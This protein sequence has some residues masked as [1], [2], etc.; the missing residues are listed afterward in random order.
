MHILRGMHRVDGIG[1]SEL[2]RRTGAATAAGENRRAFI[3]TV[4][5]SLSFKERRFA[6]AGQF[7]GG[8]KTAAFI[9]RR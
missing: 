1:V 2:R 6:I 4:V 8:R 7:H 3:V 9:V 5:W